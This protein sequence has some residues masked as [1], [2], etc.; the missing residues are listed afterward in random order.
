[1]Y[2][3]GQ[4]KAY[5][6]VGNGL[7]N[8]LERIRSVLFDIYYV[9]DAMLQEM[10]G[11][12]TKADER[13][14]W[15]PTEKRYITLKAAKALEES[16]KIQLEATRERAFREGPLGKILFVA[17]LLSTR[18][19]KGFFNNL[20]QKVTVG[21][22]LERMHGA[23]RLT[24][25]AEIALGGEPGTFETSRALTEIL[26]DISSLKST[27]A[28]AV[29][30][31][32]EIESERQLERTP[33]DIGWQIRAALTVAGT[34]AGALLGGPVGWVGA[35]AAGIAFLK[36]RQERE[37]EIKEE[38]ERTIETR[39]IVER[40]VEIQ[41]EYF[42]KSL[43]E[44]L[45][46]DLLDKSNQSIIQEL[47]RVTKQD[48]MID[49]LKAIAQNTEMV[50]DA[51]FGY[52]PKIANFLGDNRGSV[53]EL[54]APGERF[55]QVTLVDESGN[56]IFML[57]QITQQIL[58][59]QDIRDYLGGKS[60][61]I[62]DLLDPNKPNIAQVELLKAA[63]KGGPVNKDEP[64]LVGEKGPEILM[65]RSAG[66]I[67]PN[68]QIDKFADGGTFKG[69]IFSKIYQ[70]L[71]DMF[72]ISKE[73][74]DLEID[75]GKKEQKDSQQL[76][77]LEKLQALKERMKEKTQ[78]I[79]QSKVLALL[80]KKSDKDKKDKTKEEG[81]TFGKIWDFIKGNVGKI[82]GGILAGFV[83]GYLLTKIDIPSLLKKAAGFAYEQIVGMSVVGR[84][85]TF[86]IAGAGIGLIFGPL[87]LL[88]GAMIGGAIGGVVDSIFDMISGY[89][90][91]GILGGISSFITGSVPGELASI[92]GNA[93]K[94]AAMGMPI[95]FLVGGP[96]GALTGAL[97]GG[98][99]GGAF[100]ALQNMFI[101]S[102]AVG[103][104]G[105]ILTGI[106]KFLTGSVPGELASIGG[107]TGKWALIG[108][109][110]G[111]PFGGPLG[112][113]IGALVGGAFGALM[114]ILPNF[115]GWGIR[116]IGK[117]KDK[118]FKTTEEEV[119]EEINEQVANEKDPKKRR[120][121]A[122][123]L[124]K[125]RQQLIDKKIKKKSSMGN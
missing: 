30:S 111:L 29:H 80:G 40:G 39:N 31:M 10:G 79:W 118:L 23:E 102:I 58:M 75:Q 15:S 5:D 91:G 97:I 83:G 7:P 108:A 47:T 62:S 114:A 87:G 77:M 37:K 92:G 71:S 122:A 82:L 36:A 93:A 48:Q 21:R 99:L 25:A 89:Q 90:E 41:E 3:S 55:A 51:R 113:F 123:K 38:R 54:L 124:L 64:V 12:V 120:E 104:K 78:E 13:L 117:L 22:S 121:L 112:M 63:A 17:D 98:V 43:E 65:P 101:E 32:A 100:A 6:Y 88:T 81:S 70:K 28:T 57:P 16:Q 107:N 26:A 125:E 94:W 20:S 1:L 24:G 60:Y 45:G 44:R 110:I 19:G 69:E 95:G 74:L 42:A 59:L 4:D 73:S 85:A 96:L 8:Q 50:I 72:I 109:G 49:Y 2:I 103:E 86:A 27:M 18:V 68:D 76:T 56:P 53:Y 35:G 34:V 61:S 33:E 66:M 106:T 115:I 11:E 52:L 14:I 67:I 119:D 84:I 116:A 9:Q 46:S 105:G